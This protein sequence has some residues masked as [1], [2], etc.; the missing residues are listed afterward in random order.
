ME[1]PLAPLRF[2][3]ALARIDELGGSMSTEQQ[4][5]LS[6][7][8]LGDYHT[9]AKE[10]VWGLGPELVA[11]CGISAGD[12]VLDVAA[13]TGNVA[14]RAA[15]AGATVVASDPTEENFAAG[16]REARERGVQLEWVRADA[17]SL[18]FD[19]GEFD[20]VTSCL[21]AIF[22][23]DHQAVADELVRVCRPGGTIGMI[24]FT[25]ES[26]AAELFGMYERYAP[27]PP[28]SLPPIAWGSEGHVREL[29]GDRVEA[30]ELTRK[31]YFERAESP[32][33]YV[34][35]FTRTFGPTIAI[36]AALADEPERLAA[37]DRE[38]LEF[39]TRARSGPE[40]GAAEYRYEYLL[41]LAETSR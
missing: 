15:E 11:A 28:G 2:V 16:R 5:E 8:A 36:R 25:P 13:G 34:D 37:F 7:W 20:V 14:I 21:G 10:T 41:V 12:R 38:S 40:G 4:S 1:S 29:F 26:L 27:S 24:N 9:F 33:E 19:D 32:R 17:Q 39:A 30:L 18:P 23:P 3:A 35:L 6:V 22:A 31:D